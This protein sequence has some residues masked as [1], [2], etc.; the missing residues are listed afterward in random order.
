MVRRAAILLLLLPSPAFAQSRTDALEP[1]VGRERGTNIGTV[2][3]NSLKLL[4]IEH[5][6]RVLTQ[7]ETRRE[8]SGPFWA[9]Y[10]RSVR[11]PPRWRDSDACRSTRTRR[12][13]RK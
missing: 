12:I 4:M 7:E 1:A 13:R 6:T 3:G 10:R 5:A 11:I 2:F 9:D 8:L